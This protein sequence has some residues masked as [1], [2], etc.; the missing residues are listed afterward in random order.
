M[1]VIIANKYRDA[2]ANLDI[3]V[4]K[5]LEGEFTVNEIVETFKNFF[6]NKMILDVTALKDYKNIKT[7]QQ[8]SLSLDMDKLILLLDGSPE[9]SNPEYLSDLISMR[10]YNF[11]MNVEGVKWLYEHPNSYR[12]VAQYHQLDT[13]HDVNYSYNVN[14]NQPVQELKRCVVICFKD[15]TPGA[16]STTLTYIAKKQLARNYDVV[17][18]EVDKHD[19]MYFDE[20]K[21]YSVSGSE[22]GNT[23]AKYSNSDVILIDANASTVAESL[24]NE[25]IYLL[26][27]SKIQL[28]KLLA[29]DP[30]V[31]QRDKDKK[32]VLNQCM[33]SDSDVSDFEYETGLSV[34]YKI[35]PLNDQSS[36]NEDLDKFLVKLGFY[37]Q[38]VAGQSESKKGI[39]SLFGK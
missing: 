30:Q 17:A 24:S 19:F 39:M 31:L 33:L 22:L 1:N 6:F 13:T 29:R 21:M 12:D 20:D 8:L 25:V 11:T 16:G 37:K 18:L 23:I 14:V 10:I 26:E 27:P 38:D 32:I 2:L 3:E 34:F 28:N 5:K 36:N 9:T 35:P 7:L 4:I 15:V